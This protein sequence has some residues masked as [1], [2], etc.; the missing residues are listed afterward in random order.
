MHV[1]KI[2]RM[3]ASKLKEY[4]QSWRQ[5]HRREMQEF[6]QECKKGNNEIAKILVEKR[7]AANVTM[8]AITKGTHPC[9]FQKCLLQWR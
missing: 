4:L 6:N 2:A 9:E 1:T 3:Q 7:K 8:F 5:E